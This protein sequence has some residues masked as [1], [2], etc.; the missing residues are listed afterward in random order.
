MLAALGR[1]LHGSFSFLPHLGPQWPRPKWPATRLYCISPGLLPPLQARGPKAPCTSH[2]CQH[3]QK[4]PRVA[5][6]QAGYAQ[7][8]PVRFSAQ[9][10]NLSSTH[11]PSPHHPH[12]VHSPVTSTFK[13]I[14]SP[15]FSLRPDLSPQDLAPAYASS[16]LTGLLCLH[17]LLYSVSPTEPLEQ[18][19]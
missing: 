4:Q 17:L 10:V 7:G 9:V 3:T 18:V 5:P 13:H 19:C 14:Q 16:R 12:A 6:H 15:R 8:F 11:T 1:P 2:E